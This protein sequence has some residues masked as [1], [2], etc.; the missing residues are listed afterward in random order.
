MRPRRGSLGRRFDKHECCNLEYA[1]KQEWLETNGLGGFACGTILGCNTRKYHSVLTVPTS[2]GRFNLLS[3]VD[4]YLKIGDSEY[5]LNVSKYLNAPLSESLRYLESVD[6]GLFPCFTFKVHG[7]LIQKSIILLHKQNTALIKYE[8]LEGEDVL[9]HLRPL[10]SFKELHALSRENGFLRVRTFPNKDTG[11]YKVSCYEGLPSLYFKTSPESQY[12]PGP[13]WYKNFEYEVEKERGYDCIE[14]L[15]CPGI[16]EINLK[17]NQAFIFAASTEDILVNNLESLFDAEA[18][19]RQE[20]FEHCRG[21]SN[22]EPETILRYTANEFLIENYRKEKSVIAG[23]PWFEEWGRDTFIAILGLAIHNGKAD[24][25][26][27]II[28][29]YTKYEKDGLIPNYLCGSDVSYNSID[30]ALLWFRAV[31]E[32]GKKTGNYQKIITELLP[33]MKKIV[34]SYIEGR[35]PYVV[36]KDTGMLW[37]GTSETQLTWMDAT[38]WGRP[39]TSRHGYAVEINALWYNMLCFYIELLTKAKVQADAKIIK[40]RDLC[41]ANFTKEFWNYEKDCLCDVVNEQGKDRSVRPNQLYA[42]AL[43]YSMLNREQQKS[44]VKVVE[45]CLI[46]PYGLRTLDPSDPK[47][48]P[49]YRGNQDE[50]DSQYHQGTVWPWLIGSYVEAC[51][52]VTDDKEDTVNKIKKTFFPL[53]EK[54]LME[55]GVWN[56]S[57]IMDA[58]YPYLPN[59][60]FAQAWSTGELIRSLDFLKR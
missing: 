10:L 44:V 50:R 29:S 43:D 2:F 49:Y 5:Y 60:C 41:L 27:E 32:Y 34:S 17:K 9:M 51:M 38:A 25:G 7:R 53:L 36:L 15:F 39:V 59:G 31:Q 11:S 55:Y 13:D 23:Y 28:K 4:D 21:I 14:D 47:Y 33:I 35:V 30:A 1:L 3:K 48:A 22:D 16:F 26:F 20:E 57:E 40:I 52:K 12:Y 19:R 18:L 42:V 6:I 56:I 8:L 54:H 45:D 46:T 58:E 24:V 37:T